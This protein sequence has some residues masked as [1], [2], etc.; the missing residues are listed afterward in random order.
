ME[1]LPLT[2]ADEHSIYFKT[3]VKSLIQKF[4]PQQ[5]FCFAKKIVSEETSG[6]FID[7][8]YDHNYHRCLLIVTESNTRIDRE[9]QEFAN[10]HYKQ[11]KITILC[12][13]KESIAEAIRA[14]NKFFITIYNTG[15]LLYSSDGMTQSDLMVRYIPT[16]SG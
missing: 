4:Q 7:H 11:G 8:G 10:F 3:F 15:H 12:H 9:V 16:Q 13:G 5:L 2:P 1:M 14:N 6:C